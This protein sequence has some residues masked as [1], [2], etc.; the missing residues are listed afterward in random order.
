MRCLL[1]Y[2]EE[3]VEASFLQ[4]LDVAQLVLFA[5]NE[6]LG[7]LRNLLPILQFGLNL[8]SLLPLLLH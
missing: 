8:L 4:Q 7:S 3:G 6:M 1:D 2:V 5:I